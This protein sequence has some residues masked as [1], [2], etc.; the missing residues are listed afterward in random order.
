VSAVITDND[1]DTAA[2]RVDFDGTGAPLPPPPGPNVAAPVVQADTSALLGTL[3]VE[4]LNLLNLN[5]QDL[6]AADADGD[7]R[8]VRV[9][10]QPLL[11]VNLAPQSLTASA[12]LAAELGLQFTVVNDPGLLGLVAPSSVLTITAVGGG[13]IDNVAVNEL[14]ATVHFVNGS[15]LLG[16]GAELQLALLNSTTIT[17]TDAGGR[18]ASASLGTLTNLNALNTLLD[19]D[20]IKEG[21]GGNNTLDGTAADERLYGY[22]G[23]DTLNGG[24]G[25]DLLRGGSGNDTLNGGDGNDVLIDGAGQDVFNGGAGDDLIWITSTQFVSIDGGSGV[26]TLLLD[27]GLTLDLTDPALGSIANIE[28]INLGG[29]DSDNTLTLDS[30]EVIALTE[31]T[32][33]LVIQGDAGDTLNLKIGETWVAEGPMT[34]GGVAYTEY[35]FGGATLFVQDG[36]V[37]NHDVG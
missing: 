20:A 28:R 11:S 26:D 5:D 14:L 12:A 8:S 34:I 9:A 31:A 27:G 16:L 13:D 29:T 10:Y 4:A 37:V 21:D 2:T 22:G 18:T 32:D 19:T 30:A 24:G 3:G 15:A 17:A 35:T 6:I 25:N 7:L 33:T 23:D 36:I 1:G